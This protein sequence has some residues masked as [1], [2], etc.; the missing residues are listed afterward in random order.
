MREQANVEMTYS[1]QEVAIREG[2]MELSVV[3]KMRFAMPAQNHQL[4]A[5]L[6]EYS[7]ILGQQFKR[8]I[9]KQAMEG[10]D[11][12]L[13]REKMAARD[14]GLVRRGKKPYRV[15]TRF[16]EAIIDRNRVSMRNGRTEIPAHYA[17]ETPQSV[18]ITPG[19]KRTICDLVIKESVSQAVAEIEKQAGWPSLISRGSCLNILHEEGARLIAAQEQRAQAVFEEVPA[20]KI[21]IVDG[22]RKESNPAQYMTYDFGY[23]SEE[24]ELM[25]GRV[26]WSW[27]RRGEMGEGALIYYEK[28]QRTQ[29]EGLVIVQVDEIKV[30]AQPHSGRKEIW[31]YTGVVNANERSYYLSADSSRKLFYQLGSLLAVLEVHKGE[32]EVYII[33]D[34]ARW[35]RSWYE[36]L[37][38]ARKSMALCWY[39]LIDKCHEL[40]VTSLGK[41]GSF[42]VENQLL[43]KLWSGDVS[44]ALLELDIYKQRVVSQAAFHKLRKYL[45]E[46]RPFITNYEMRRFSE[47]FIAST[48]VEK[49]NDWSVASRCK[50]QSRSWAAAGVKAVAALLCA[51]RNGELEQWRN[52]GKLPGWK[53]AGRAN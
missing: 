34:G 6:E 44:G 33:S 23:G 36:R 17:W 26:I 38:I 27:E 10:A 11:E 8:Q 45:Q 39:H 1:G 51:Q 7:S 50:G 53:E 2:Q 24:E 52:S 29:A 40:L 37:P 18:Y 13:L 43:S 46:R 5:I 4:P 47:Q 12:E 16:G 3:V 28:E 9:Y 21:L 35:I 19:L 49:F 25:G 22:N 20:A 14:G 42:R 15:K 48:R 31:I 30:A 32:R 41:E